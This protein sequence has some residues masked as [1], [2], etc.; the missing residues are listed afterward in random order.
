M[1]G[2]PE[3]IFLVLVIGDLFGSRPLKL[4]IVNS[5]GCGVRG[6]YRER[7][8]SWL[9]G[10]DLNHRPLGYEANFSVYVVLNGKTRLR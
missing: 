10:V 4:E 5:D 6:S 8:F 2:N 3:I 1:T 7:R 9:R